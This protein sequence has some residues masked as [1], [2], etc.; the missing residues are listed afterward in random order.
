[1]NGAWGEDDYGVWVVW[2][3][4][5]GWGGCDMIFPTETA[6]RAYLANPTWYKGGLHCTYTPFGMSAMQA[7]ELTDKAINT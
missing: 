1:M 4:H 2:S 3:D 6:A 5:E 7:D